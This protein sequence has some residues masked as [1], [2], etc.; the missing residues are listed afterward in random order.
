MFPFLSLIGLDGC[1]LKL[2]TLNATHFVVTPSNAY[3]GLKIKR[4]GDIQI[5]E[6][7]WTTIRVLTEWFTFLCKTASLGDAFEVYLSGTGNTPTGDVLDT[8]LALTQDREWL[9]TRTAIGSLSFTGT[10]QIRKIA[11]P[12]NI[13]SASAAINAEVD[14]GM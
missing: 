14:S 3:A 13:V 9:L 6:G 8:W 11:N 1:K 5:K 2:T 4:S 12:S 10:M 7:G